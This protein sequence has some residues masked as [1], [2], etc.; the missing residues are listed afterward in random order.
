MNFA[1]TKAQLWPRTDCHARQTEEME[2]SSAAARTHQRHS[3]K[4]QLKSVAAKR[5]A[6]G[7]HSVG[8]K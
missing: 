2:Q 8:G 4:M 3:F 7:C 6:G 1:L 5:D